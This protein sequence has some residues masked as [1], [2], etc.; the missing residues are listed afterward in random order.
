MRRLVTC[1][2]FSMVSFSLQADFVHYRIHASILVPDVAEAADLIVQWCE[3]AGGY[4][5]TKSTESVVL[6]YPVAQA[7]SVR[8][9]LLG[10]TEELYSFTMELTDYQDT[11]KSL[12]SSIKS[13]EEILAR[14][15]EYV[16]KADLAG[17][18]AIEQEITTL[19]GQIESYR[20]KLRKALSDSQYAHVTVLLS[21]LGQS[22]PEDR[23][24]SF[25]WVN[26]VDFYQFMREIQ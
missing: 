14:N 13:R 3:N 1:I 24:S 26:S 25:P 21:F 20:G 19:L 22:I 10:I 15:L 2:L 8:G 4:F 17:T 9:F 18:L 6:R 16:D 5:V 7:K 11:V 23:P 12:Q